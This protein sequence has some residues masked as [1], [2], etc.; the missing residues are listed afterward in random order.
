MK[1][2]SQKGTSRRPS[3][4]LG[5]RFYFRRLSVLLPLI[6]LPLRL[7]PILV[8]WAEISKFHLCELLGGWG[9]KCGA[10][11]HE[12]ISAIPLYLGQWGFLGCLN[13]TKVGAMPHPFS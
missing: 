10:R 3:P 12:T 13:V 9:T 6:V 2:K 11:Y 4:S 7:S 1:T 8:L 5:G